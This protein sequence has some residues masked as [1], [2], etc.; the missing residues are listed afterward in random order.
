MATA[1]VKRAHKAYD[2]TFKLKAVDF[3]EKESKEAAARQF[4]VDPKT[5]RELIEP[6]PVYNPASFRAQGKNLAEGNR[7]PG[8]YSRIY[9]IYITCSVYN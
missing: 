1:G 4:G 8:F 6:S 2:V 5:I 3:A 7:T 9:G